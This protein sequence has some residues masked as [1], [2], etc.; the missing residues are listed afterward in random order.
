MTALEATS[1]AVFSQRICGIGVF[2]QSLES[3]RRTKNALLNAANSMTLAASS[4]SSPVM[5]ARRE[6]PR[7]PPSPSPPPKSRVEGGAPRPP[8]ISVVVDPGMYQ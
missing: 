7:P 3:P 5:E 4:T 1:T 8:I 2:T 6:A